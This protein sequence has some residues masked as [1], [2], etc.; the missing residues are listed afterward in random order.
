[1]LMTLEV[2][3]NLRLSVIITTVPENI[4]EVIF[5]PFA[6]LLMSWFV[7]RFRFLKL[8]NLDKYGMTFLGSL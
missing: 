5:K 8:V 6:C 1:L 2:S 4:S 3:S 7:W